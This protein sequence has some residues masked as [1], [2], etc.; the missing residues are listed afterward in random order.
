MGRGARLAMLAMLAVIGTFD[1][2]DAA[3]VQPVTVRD[4]Y[5]RVVTIPAPPQRIIPVYSSNVELVEALG[6]ADRIVGIEDFTRYPPEVLKRPSIGGRLGISV[7]ATVALRPDLVIVT[8]ARQAVFQLVDPMQRLG[9]PIIVLMQRNVDE[10]FSNIRLLGRATGVPDRGA[11]LAASLEDRLAQIKNRIKD[12]PQPRVVMIR[13][14]IGNGLL[15]IAQADTYTGDAIVLAGG[16]FALSGHSPISQVSPE[17]IIDSDPDFLLYAGAQRELDDLVTNP[18]W[19][20][21]RAVKNHHAVVVNRAELLIPGPRTIAGV[22]HL[23]SIFHP[24]AAEP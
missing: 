14:R 7:D 6:L 1:I 13:G 10:I 20:E 8:P 16:Q 2:A 4:A 24:V 21:M 17:A 22:E 12:L 18:G 9:V 23:A 15:L 3:G 11:A 5:D 19:S